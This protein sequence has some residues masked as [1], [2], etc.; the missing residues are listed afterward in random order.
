MT[1]S[2]KAKQILDSSKVMDNMEQ[3]DTL[4]VWESYR[5]QAL[6]WRAIALLQIPATLA[7]V[8]FAIVLWTTRSITL[9]VPLKPAPGIYQVQDIPDIEFI[10]TVTEF[11]NL[12]ASYQPSTARRQFDEAKK[13]LVEPLL[14]TFT[15]DMIG[16]ELKAI[17]STARTQLFYVDPAKTK[18]TREGG[19]ITVSV[20]GDR[21]KI[22]A[23]KEL[24][25]T[26]V[27]YTVSLKT[28][29]RNKLNPYGIVITNVNF[30]ILKR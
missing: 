20:E 18:V 30:E 1:K 28:I 17:E 10:E 19:L 26:N 8:V 23:G 12:V 25:G 3:S 4:R 24:P 9:N 16:N 15:A 21:L 29:P 5:D 27:R 7:S 13:M 14:S 22:V 11:V 2:A 6:L